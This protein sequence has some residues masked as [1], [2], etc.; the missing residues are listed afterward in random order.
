MDFPT[1]LMEMTEQTMETK[2]LEQ[3]LEVYENGY[4]E[5]MEEGSSDMMAYY[6]EKMEKLKAMQESKEKEISFGGMHAGLTE[7]QWR[8]KAMKEFVAN[9]ESRDYKR[10]A[11]NAV[12][13]ANG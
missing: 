4:Q 1:E 12:K 10:Y 8:E 5:A 6:E 9:G 11:E 2:E 7:N 13:A 3:L